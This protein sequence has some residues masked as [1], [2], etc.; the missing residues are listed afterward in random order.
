VAEAVETPAPVEAPE[1]V[2]DEV[3]ET[4]A[5]EV[6]EPKAKAPKAKSSGDDLKIIEGIG[7]KIEEILHEAGIDSFAVLAGK[8]AEAIRE[9]LLS[10]GSRFKMFDPTTWPEQAQLA[11][12]GKMDELEA[13]KKE[14]NAGKK[15]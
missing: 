11:A 14:L 13:L 2:A 7:P 5:D 15:E 1:V 10:H 4:P 12:D 8:D 6:K 3:V 9:I